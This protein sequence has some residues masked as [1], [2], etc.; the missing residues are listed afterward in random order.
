M[1]FALLAIS[2]AVSALGTVAGFGGGVFL[3]PIMVLG[4]QIPI[5]AAIG[6][7][8]FSL[9]PSSLL[10]TI[11]NA[12]HKTIDFKLAI[13]L[14]IPTAVG[15]I[16]GAKLTSYVPAGPLE[17]IFALFLLFL[18]YRMFRVQAKAGL[19]DRLIARLN[20]V[21]PRFDRPDYHVGAWAAG[22]F[23]IMA[24]TIAGLFGIG[25]GVLKTPIMIEVF[26]VPARRAAATALAMI[27]I[28]SLASGL[29]HYALGHVDLSLLAACATGFLLGAIVGQLLGLKAKDESIKRIIAVSIGLAGAAVAVHAFV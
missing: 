12:R 6:V 15:A 21:R 17:I 5:E 29:E 27:V 9:F 20:A 10:S 4:F 25:G 14:E 7:T 3:V 22:V 23:G 11:F 2:C 16:F 28:T 24:G 13:I 1:Y 8:A 26:K 19:M 18:S